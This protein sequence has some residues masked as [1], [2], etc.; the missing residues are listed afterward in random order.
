MTAFLRVQ[1]QR[2]L[3]TYENSQKC[4]SH[5]SENINCPSHWKACERISL[6]RKPGHAE[7]FC[8]IK[9]QNL[10]VLFSASL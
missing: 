8:H 1:L 10:D 4:Y 3:R 2:E 9:H 7:F 6:G 5:I